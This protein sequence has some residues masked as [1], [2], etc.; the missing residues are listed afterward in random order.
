[1]F[2]FGAL[3]QAAVKVGTTV[4][5]RKILSP[6]LIV[7]FQGMHKYREGV[8]LLKHNS[9]SAWEV[10]EGLENK[11]LEKESEDGGSWKWDQMMKLGTSW[12]RRLRKRAR[13]ASN[14]CGK[15]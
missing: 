10:L 14:R 7:P 8:S 5:I 9:E 4:E 12:I 11:D 13:G 3:L 6:L 2:C 1:M 15:H